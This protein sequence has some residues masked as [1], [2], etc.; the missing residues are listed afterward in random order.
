MQTAQPA[1][2]VHSAVFYRDDQEYLDEVLPFVR[3]GLDH[4]DPVLVTVPA[5]KLALLRDALGAAAD[6]V[7]VHTSD[8]G[9]TIHAYLAVV[10]AEA[11]S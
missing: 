2:L 1:G 11:A 4:G 7:R 9:T 6:L 10:I 3:G 8:S 5:D